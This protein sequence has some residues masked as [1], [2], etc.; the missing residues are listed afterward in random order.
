M[1]Y[2][3]S[4]RNCIQIRFTVFKLARACHSLRYFTVARTRRRDATMFNVNKYC[5][6]THPCVSTSEIRS[7]TWYR[8]LVAVYRHSLTRNGVPTSENKSCIEYFALLRC[9]GCRV[10]L[11]DTSS[12]GNIL[13]ELRSIKFTFF[14]AR[15]FLRQPVTTFLR[16]WKF[17]RAGLHFNCKQ[18]SVLY[19]RRVRQR[20]ELISAIFEI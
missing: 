12:F 14:H 20:N 18:T 10:S 2:D 5:T 1:P 4:V 6:L 13:V 19:A 8:L 7:S 17:S 9:L 16:D 3:L 15:R 11:H